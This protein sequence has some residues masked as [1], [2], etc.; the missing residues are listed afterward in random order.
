MTIRPN[1]WC[2]YITATIS[3]LY[4]VVHAMGLFC[5]NMYFVNAL[6]VT[7]HWLILQLMEINFTNSYA[8][9]MGANILN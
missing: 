8:W 2:L 1:P 9:T 4:I 6:Q 7:I 5:A 3:L